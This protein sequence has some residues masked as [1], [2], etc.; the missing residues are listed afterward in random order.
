MST[1]PIDKLVHS[2]SRLP[3]IGEKTAIRLAFFIL[4]QKSSYARE[5]GQNLLDLHENILFCEKCQNLTQLSP[6]KTCSDPKREGHVLLVVETPQ[7]MLALERSHYY[8]GTYHILHGAISPLEGIKPEHLKI[9]ELLA[10]IHPEEIEEVILGTNPNVE[11]EA[12]AL[13]L[14]DLLTPLVQVTRLATGLPAGSG[15]EY[16]DPLTL[17]R[18]LEGRQKMAS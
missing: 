5:L 6:C 7:D 8:R 4:Q 11:G 15:I 3:G 10:R 1:S 13:Y 18:A 12:T 9:K 14:S 2:L 16:L 17:Q